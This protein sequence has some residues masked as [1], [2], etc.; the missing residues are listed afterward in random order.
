LVA[1]RL[2]G[3]PAWIEWSQPGRFPVLDVP[4]DWV[5]A[6]VDGGQVVAV[7]NPSASGEGDRNVV[8][9][10]KPVAAA[11]VV[12]ASQGVKVGDQVQG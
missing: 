5:V 9:P 12:P 1:Y 10:A 3:V 7:S 4:K 11:L 6:W 8:L 2:R